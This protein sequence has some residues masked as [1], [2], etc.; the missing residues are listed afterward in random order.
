[1]SRK[2]SIEDQNRNCRDYAEARGWPV[3]EEYVRADEA[4]TG[5][6]M[7]D[8][9][10]LQFLLDEAQTKPRPFDVLLLDEPSRLA[11]KLSDVLMIAEEL[12]FAGVRLALVNL[13][14][15]SDNPNFPTLLT[16]YGMVDEQNS[17]RMKHRVHRGQ[18]G[19]VLG[20]FTSGSRCFGYRSVKILAPDVIEAKT[21]AD[22]LG[23]RWVVVDSE[24]ATI[25][26]IYR[27]FADGRSVWQITCTLNAE[28]VPAAR[29]PRIA[30]PPK[31]SGISV[32]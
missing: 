12:R 19:R 14:L 10:G 18:K 3:L 7:R 26:R 6:T 11:R 29:K 17:D 4:K 20:G 2:A 25:R 31:P 32:W 13:K 24:A 9:D 30:P 1:M 22:Y 27:M 8:R 28:K 23:A 21:H 5:R 15:E 16:L